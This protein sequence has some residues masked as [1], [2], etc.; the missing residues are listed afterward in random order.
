NAVASAL[1]LLRWLTKIAVMLVLCAGWADF[2]MPRARDRRR[3]SMLRVASCVP[4]Y[5][6]EAPIRDSRRDAMISQDCIDAQ[7]VRA[8]ARTSSVF[9]A[10]IFGYGAAQITR[11][12]KPLRVS[13]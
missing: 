6:V 1:S 5:R 10:M 2:P 8:F 13:L 4:G 12:S 7:T 3:G 11:Y 9:T